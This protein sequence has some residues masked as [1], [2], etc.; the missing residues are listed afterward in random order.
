MRKERHGTI[1][2]L[3]Q[4]LLGCEQEVIIF[5]IIEA[6]QRHRVL[7]FTTTHAQDDYRRC[8]R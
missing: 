7:L 1:F 2:L 3:T 8:R 4:N 5:D 6:C